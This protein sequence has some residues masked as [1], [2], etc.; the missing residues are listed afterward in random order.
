VVCNDERGTQA[1]RL[2][3]RAENCS[4]VPE[5]VHYPKTR[6]R[7]LQTFGPEHSDPDLGIAVFPPRVHIH[8]T[9]SIIQ[10]QATATLPRMA[11]QA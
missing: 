4:L 3:T 11:R 1:S 2:G 6:Q 9:R 5:A 7:T 8:E 10:N